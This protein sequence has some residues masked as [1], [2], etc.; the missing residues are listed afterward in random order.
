M[1]ATLL[2]T[3]VCCAVAAPSLRAQQSSSATY[4]VHAAALSATMTYCRTKHGP[5]RPNSAGQECF[6]RAKEALN[7]VDL[8][9]ASS[10]I[11]RQCSDPATFNTCLTPEIGKVV[12]RILEVFESKRL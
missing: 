3:A 10:R 2:L 7:E 9:A 4:A 12:Y 11:D 6:H 1:K 5:L 8:K